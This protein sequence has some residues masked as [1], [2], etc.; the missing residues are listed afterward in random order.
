VT[1]F[2]V[3]A[4]LAA[5]LAAILSSVACRSKSSTGPVGPDPERLTLADGSKVFVSPPR[6]EA[7]GWFPS[8]PSAIWARPRDG[9]EPRRL[10]FGPASVADPTVL[11]DG[12]VLFVSAMPQ[13]VGAKERLALFAVNND[14][15]GVLS[16]ACQH[17][18][19]P[20]VHRPREIGEDRVAFAA[21][22]SPGGPERWEFVLSARPFR[23][24]AVVPAALV[25]EVETISARLRKP[26]GRLSTVDPAKKTGILICLDARRNGESENPL[27][28]ARVRIL[29]QASGEAGS[30]RSLGEVPTATDGSFLVEVPADVPL[31]V[32]SL[33][34]DGRVLKTLPPWFWVRPGENRGCIGCHEPHGIAPRNQRPLAAKKE[35][36]K[37][38]PR[39]A[40]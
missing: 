33:D 29:A 22:D 6:N 17:D 3:V 31:G 1:A 20:V 35:P 38:T 32:E 11:D 28:V 13:A 10:T 16:Y 39:G 14:G 24:R 5:G 15:T 8:K 9:G 37:L 25:P 7:D 2:R 40:S 12:R 36:A 19:A 4:A 18:G 21:A 34:A 27:P 26:M 30:T 23:S